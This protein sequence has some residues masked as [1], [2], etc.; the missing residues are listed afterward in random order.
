MSDMC[1]IVCG[2][3]GDISNR[4]WDKRCCICK[5]G[6]LAHEENE[7]CIGCVTRGTYNTFRRFRACLD[8]NLIPRGCGPLGIYDTILIGDSSYD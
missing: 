6:V 5:V 3:N 2:A 4:Y 1:C 7:A 8:D